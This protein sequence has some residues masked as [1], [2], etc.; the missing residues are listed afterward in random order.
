MRIE[1]EFF[2]SSDVVGIARELL[3]KYLFVKIDG[4][5]C[6]GYITETEAYAGSVD[7]AS[8]A[9]QN[10]RTKRTEVMFSEGG[11]TYVYL[12]YGIHAML[13][14]VSAE[15][16]IPHA[17]LVRG[18]WPTH[19]LETILGRLK[20]SKVSKR[21]FNGPGKITRALGILTSHNN[22]DLQEDQ[23]WLEDRGMEVSEDDII[24]GSR[25]GIDYAEE[26]ALLPYRFKLKE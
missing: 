10:K 2:L 25:I 4:V 5:I 26:D 21:M 14:F 12:C 20:K 6:G 18:F 13:N 16:G 7:K 8:H 19:G 11:S 1:K 22:L 24:V 3:G 23:I 15:E 9:Y 17:I